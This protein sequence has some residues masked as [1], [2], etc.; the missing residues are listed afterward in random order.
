MQKSGND[1]LGWRVQV[2]W[3]EEE[4]W[5]DGMITE[6]SPDNGYYVCYDDGDEKWQCS[7]DM[8][9]MR[10]ISNSIEDTSNSQLFSVSTKVTKM[11]SAVAAFK[12]PKTEKV[13]E[14]VVDEEEMTTERK[15]EE[16]W[17]EDVAIVPKV[18][19]EEEEEEEED[20]EDK[21][22]EEVITDSKHATVS[23][24]VANPP[25]TADI[26]PSVISKGGS[27]PRHPTT[28]KAAR[29]A[30][31]FRDK[32]ELLE[33]KRSLESTQQQLTT[34]L[35]ELT[36]KLKVAEQTSASLKQSIAEY[37]SKLTVA[38][39]D[40]VTAPQAKPQTTQ[41]ERI[42]ELKLKNRQMAKENNDVKYPF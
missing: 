5:F 35:E 32:E 19:E 38:S 13:D 16:E 34:E 26:L 15:V 42:L 41:E 9:V 8:E 20:D 22:E 30:M 18:E 14:T 10:F 39:L 37:T 2:Y 28:K 40:P 24:E 17:K 12:E 4:E 25:R 33:M 6:Y 36:K 11:V 31:F 7:N 1:A 27:T 3:E 21:D 29:N 23:S